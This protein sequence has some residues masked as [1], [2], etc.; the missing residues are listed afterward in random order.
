[1]M[2][3]EDLQQSGQGSATSATVLVWDLPLRVFHWALAAVVLTGIAAINLDNV[4]LHV[5]CGQVVLALVLFRIVWGFV[6][7]EYARF[8]S[9]VRG[10]AAIASYARSLRRPPQEFHAGHN[11]LGGMV[12][13]LMLALLLLQAVSGLFAN[14]DIVTEGPLA[15]FVSKS[16][17]N[18][19]TTLHDANAW[20]II[21]LIVVHIVAV[22][23]YLIRYRDNLIH[24]MV[25]GLKRVPGEARVTGI[26]GIRPMLA[27]IAIAFSALA[28]WLAFEVPNWIAPLT[29]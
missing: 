17:S 22:F 5:R 16:V 26:T 23:V 18:A 12:V 28:A 10:P 20:L 19:I 1:M 2:R 25:T 9:F 24:P 13:V 4:D 8:T 29:F 7:P 27:L 6:G 15:R 11:P 21:G 3:N 14:D